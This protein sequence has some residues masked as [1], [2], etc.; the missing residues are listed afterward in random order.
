MYNWMIRIA[1]MLGALVL[2]IAL[3]LLGVPSSYAFAL[4]FFLLGIF[5]EAPVRYFYFI[6][7]VAMIF[8]GVFLG[9]M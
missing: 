7:S 6:V 8:T 4:F 1:G 5:N 2:F 3:M 9:G